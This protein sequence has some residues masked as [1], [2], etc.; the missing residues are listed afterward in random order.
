MIGH[1][2]RFRENDD[3]P[4]WR[5]PAAGA[6]NRGGGGGGGALIQISKCKSALEVWD[7]FLILLN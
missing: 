4:L 5:G 1:H 2:A 7:V 6:L 3:L